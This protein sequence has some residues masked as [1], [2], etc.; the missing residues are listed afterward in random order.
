MDR[1]SPV[2]EQHYQSYLEQISLLD[3]DALALKLGGEVKD[4]GKVLSLPL[5][6]TWYD[7]SSGEITGPGLKKPGYDA[8]VILCRY[9]LM[10]PDELPR[11]QV[12]TGFRDLKDSGPL[13]VY[14]KDNVEKKIGDHFAGGLDRLKTMLGQLG[15]YPPDLDVSYDLAV[16]VD[17]LPRIPMV[18]LFN[19][20]EPGFPASCSVLFHR[21]V[22]SF[23]D[24]ECIAMLGYRLGERLC[25]PK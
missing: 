18:V 17:G 12:W 2:F 5:L 1:V 19:D 9:L 24:A 7:I 15:A 22:E 14:F 4:S 13:T 25:R 21:H 8:C 20:A 10:C 3:F 11:D 6:G 16:Q 23:L